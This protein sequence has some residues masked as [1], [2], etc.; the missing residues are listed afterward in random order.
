ML[1]VTLFKIKM[2]H[3]VTT[4]GLRY[5]KRNADRSIWSV[6]A[7]Y[8]LCGIDGPIVV[9]EKLD[10]TTVYFD[11]R[12]DDN[13]EWRCLGVFSHRGNAILLPHGTNRGMVAVTSGGFQGC[14]NIAELAVKEM[15]LHHEWLTTEHLLHCEPTYDGVTRQPLVPDDA[16]QARIYTEFLF[17]KAGKI[18]PDKPADGSYDKKA[19]NKFYAFEMMVGQDPD[20]ETRPAKIWR[21]PDIPSGVPM[22]STS[23]Y[24]HEGAFRNCIDSTLD[25]LKENHREKEGVVMYF[26]QTNEGIK[27]RT[28]TTETEKVKHTINWPDDVRGDQI[29]LRKKLMA[30][31]TQTGHTTSAQKKSAIKDKTESKQTGLESRDN[32]EAHVQRAILA[33]AW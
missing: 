4:A 15:D 29:N 32:V 19:L 14:T 2:Q 26:P 16:R 17:P 22:I 24:P 5:R 12:K 27:I 31:Y 13:G 33:E 7:K 20:D 30:M 21:V 25:W 1:K 23:T 6:I 28:G 11:Y 18:I 10:G 9:T 3:H 8:N